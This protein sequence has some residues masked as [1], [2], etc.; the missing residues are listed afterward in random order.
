[1]IKVTILNKIK[2]R[3]FLRKYIKRWVKGELWKYLPKWRG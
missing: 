2:Y 3:R 1:V